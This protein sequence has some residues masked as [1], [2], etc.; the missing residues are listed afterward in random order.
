VEGHV[1][2]TSGPSQAAKE[3]LSY[4]MRNPYAADNLEGFARWRLLSE[5]VHRKVDETHLALSWLVEHGFL[6]ETSSPGVE[7]TFSFN[8]E[9]RSEAERLLTDPGASSSADGAKCR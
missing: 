7:P 1:S 5:V 9:K 3:I 6:L 2:S 4:F 8:P